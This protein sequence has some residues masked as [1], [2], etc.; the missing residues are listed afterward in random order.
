LEQFC[1]HYLKKMLTMSNLYG[2]ISKI[3]LTM[4]KGDRMPDQDD[5][6][7]LAR[8]WHPAY[9]SYL[10]S[11][12]ADVVADEAI[13]VATAM[14]RCCGGCPILPELSET[15]WQY[16]DMIRTDSLWSNSPHDSGLLLNDRL[17]ALA[18]TVCDDRI[19]TVAIR[20]AK[21]IALQLR[22]GDI[23]AHRLF[24]LRLHLA[25]QIIRDLIRHCFLDAARAIAVGGRFRSSS[26]SQAFYDNVMKHIDSA[27]PTIGTRLANNPT[28][29]GIKRYRIVPKL[30][31]ASMMFN[32]DFRL[33]G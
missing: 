11:G 14:L 10:D 2:I 21:I 31:T 8:Q 18:K 19:G 30:T 5:F 29:K 12:S 33:D 27:V 16:R 15:L 7:P 32:E 28:G 26:E 4:S 24:E 22:R 13:R 23:K 6:E 17:D 20:S 9:D 25:S 3:I 1:K